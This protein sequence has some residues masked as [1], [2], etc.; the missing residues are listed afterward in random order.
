MKKTGTYFIPAMVALFFL[1]PLN[2]CSKD[3]KQN[4]NNQSISEEIKTISSTNELKSLLENSDK[5]LIFDLYADWCLPCKILS[6]IFSSLAKEQKSNAEFYRINV[7]K[8]PELSYS[9]GVRGIPY[10][11]FVKNRE[12]VYSLTGVNPKESYE[13]VI[14][15]CGD[16]TNELCMERLK[17]L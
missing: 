2:S 12:I 9:F 3:N 13:K 17:D 10:V 5:L 15:S 16:A 4:Q 1:L 7:D 11:V 6:P 8:S 14:N